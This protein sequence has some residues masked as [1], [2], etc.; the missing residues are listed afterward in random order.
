MKDAGN[1]VSGETEA[2]IIEDIGRNE[3][4]EYLLASATADIPNPPSRSLIET[5][6]GAS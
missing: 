3:K 2:D 5:C 1:Q 6:E 4:S